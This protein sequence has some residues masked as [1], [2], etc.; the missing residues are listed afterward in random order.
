MKFCICSG[1]PKSTC[2]CQ[3]VTDEIVRGALFQAV[4]HHLESE[5]ERGDGV[6][7]DELVRVRYQG[8]LVAGRQ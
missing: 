5:L 3:R 1:N 2:L 4:A 6:A 7:V 8:W